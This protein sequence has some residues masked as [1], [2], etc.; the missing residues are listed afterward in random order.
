MAHVVEILPCVKQW[1]TR[2]TEL[3]LLMAWRCKD[4]GHQQNDIDL[5]KPGWNGQVNCWLIDISSLDK[6]T[7]YIAVELHAL[8]ITT[9]RPNPHT[10]PLHVQAPTTFHHPAN[11]EHHRCDMVTSS[12]GNLFRVTGHLCGEFTGHRWISRT[13]AS[14]AEF[15]F[16]L[17]SAPE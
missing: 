12:N 17:W 9:T 11:I 14:D 10:S 3:W 8:Q 15:W 4:S 2:F 13:K 7:H 6:Y 5:V 1:P 16:F